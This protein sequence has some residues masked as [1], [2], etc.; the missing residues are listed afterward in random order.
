MAK[1]I[2]SLSNSTIKLIR[3]L[4][5]RKNRKQLGLFFI[6]GIRQVGEAVDSNFPLQMI[7]Y[8]PALLTAD[9]AN[10]I[11]ENASRS[12]V[13]LI[14]VSD[15]VF[16]SF[17]IKDGPQ[18]IAAVGYERYYKIT[19]I[20]IEGLWIALENIQ[21]PGNL[22]SILRSLDGAGGKG[23]FLVGQST[24]PFHP[25]AVRSSMGAVFYTPI[26]QSSLSDFG[27]HVKN[28]DIFCVGTSCETADSYKEQDYPETMILVMG[29]EQKGITNAMADVCEVLVNIPMTGRVDSLNIANAASIVL[30]E[31]YTRKT[32]ND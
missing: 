26:I 6:E 13:E 14:E 21:D 24:D 18:G 3:T 8:C 30:F 23:L 22:G 1:K 5:N 12:G 31:I 29:S 7:L 11:L 15:E 4:Q 25:T 28:N 16:Q 19:E 17:S 20:K 2:T 27:N 32:K 9:Y 10:E